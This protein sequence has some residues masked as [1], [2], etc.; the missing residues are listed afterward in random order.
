MS[1]SV[2]ASAPST[3]HITAQN[4][5]GIKSTIKSIIQGILIMVGIQFLLGNFMG[6]K[7]STKHS[8][9]KSGDMIDIPSY[10]SQPSSLSNGTTYTSVPHII[11][12]IW[13]ANTLVDIIIIISP[14]ITIE[15]ISTTPKERVIMNEVAFHLGNFSNERV[16]D[17]F[18]DLPDELQNNG[19]LWG[20]FYIGITGENLDPSTLHY[21]PDRS[22][23]FTWPL[24]EYLP[25]KKSMKT[26]NLLVKTGQT[27]DLIDDISPH[28]T[29]V[30]HYHPNF[31]MSFIPDTGVLS[32]PSIH[33]SM[34]P[35]FHLDSSNSRDG[36]G[37]NGRYYPVLFINKFWQLRSHM[38]PLN[39]TV[40]RLPIH[41]KLNNMAN[42]K[43]GIISSIDE[44]AKRSSRAAA[45]GN[46]L[47]GG[48]DGSELEMIK[49]ILF[50]T[51]P[52]LLGTTIIVSII[53][54]IFEMLAF[55]SDISHYRN[56]KN[57]IGISIR[58]IFGNCFMQGVILLYLLDN[59]ENT[60][61]MILISQGMGIVLEFW[62]I[63]TIVDI[64]I[65]PSDNI[66][67]FRI[68]FKDKHTL[69][70]TEE[71]T[72]EYDALAFKYLY[73]VA[74]PLLLA[75][76]AYSLMYE[77]HKSWYS[78]VIATLVGS[79][80]AY[81]FLMMVPSLYINYRL[82]SVAHMP[83]KAMTYK[84]L[85]TFIDDLFAFTVK[86]PTLHRL[87]TL[88]DDV[89]FFIYLYQSWKYKVDYTRINEFGQG[90]DETVSEVTEKK[91]N[92][93]SSANETKCI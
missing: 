70:T 50:E 24:T 41:I 86:M 64:C 5:G 11:A 14:S 67:G 1:P 44:A 20:H 40:K 77:T 49:K 87:A 59:N 42:W 85:N 39:S 65:C 2:S 48:G 23:H 46:P 76:A 82:K 4:E 37:Q 28:T 73:I 89:I 26:R 90:G 3:R 25:L 54:M 62:K 74:I 92:D 6:N 60:S 80:Y 16:V 10:T 52:I 93:L 83:A 33:S 19:T 15:P 75:Y 7:P 57:N 29:I 45:H 32:F 35:Y 22:F 30:S 27:E 81:G 61:W 31:T 36:T 84:F 18:F 58:S 63:T 78:F 53:H 79:V 13:P 8:N 68:E 72:K 21:I 47:P 56:K 9:N 51:N 66:I 88:R 71:K 17:T 12:P 91:S 38:N 55:K 69:S 34:R 43:F